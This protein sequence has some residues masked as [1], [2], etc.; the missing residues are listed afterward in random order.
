M[1]RSGTPVEVITCKE[2]NYLLPEL[3][4]DE[5]YQEDYYYK[6]DEE[7]GGSEH[8]FSSSPE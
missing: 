5:F 1:N 2:E 6:E 3:F 4:S 8:H 7:L